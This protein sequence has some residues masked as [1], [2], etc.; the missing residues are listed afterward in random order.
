MKK[1]LFSL[2]AVGVTSALAIG[3]TRAYFSDTQSVLGNSITT[4]VI[5][6]SVDQSK[7]NVWGNGLNFPVNLVP[8]QSTDFVDAHG[9]SHDQ[10]IVITLD[11]SSATPDHLELAVVANSFVDGYTNGFGT[12]STLD[13]YTKAIMVT[14]LYNET[15]GWTWHGLM[16]LIN[17]SADGDASNTSL[18]DLT[19]TV[20]RPIVAGSTLNVIGFTLELPA[21]A[22]NEFQGDSM[23]L[24]FTVGAAQVAGQTVL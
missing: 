14:R 8:G 11:P 3:A 21:T 24:D 22:G 18:Y 6:I 15:D 19:H 13:D 20:I 10:R 17:K 4:G 5:K 1:L 7:N 2:L 23:S 16:G 12:A 9:L